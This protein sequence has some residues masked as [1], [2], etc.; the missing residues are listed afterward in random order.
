MNNSRSRVPLSQESIDDKDA[1]AQYDCGAKCYMMPE[2][3]Y[4][5][6]KI[7]CRGK[8]SG[9]VLDIGTGTGLLAIELAKHS[10][11]KL[12][13]VGIDISNNMVRKGVQNVNDAGL[14][15]KISFINGTASSLPFDTESFDIV[16][17]YASLHHWF[18]PVAVFNEIERI[19]KKDGCIIIRENK[20]VNDNIFW[21]CFIWLLTRFMNRRHRENWPKVI[22]A[23]Y[24]IPEIE[25]IIKQSQ[26]RKCKIYSDFIHFDMAIE[27]N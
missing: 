25:E 3:K 13:I 4:F 21:R 1:I 12:S 10:D 5:T 19:T 15:D 18:D 24:T 8:N 22:Q 26:L 23:C 7:N 16:I 11:S 6:W 2:Y 17:S 14:Q 20:R 9:R 27:S